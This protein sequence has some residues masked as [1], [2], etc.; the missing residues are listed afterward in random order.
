MRREKSNQSATGVGNGV[1][2]DQWW[3]FLIGLIQWLDWGAQLATWLVH[4]FAYINISIY[5]TNSAYICKK[6]PY[7]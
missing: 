4:Y 6:S 5:I 3:G 1:K 7:I 2:L